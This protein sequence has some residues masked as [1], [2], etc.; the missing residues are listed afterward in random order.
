[1]FGGRE[2]DNKCKVFMEAVPDRTAN[3]LL[4]II[5]KWV[6]PGP[7][8]WSDSW[9]SYNRI[10]DLPEGYKHATVNHSQ[11]FVD[12]ESGTCTNRIESDWRHGKAEFPRFGTRPETYSSYLAV[13]MW[14]RKY[15]GEYL[16]MQ[17][18]RDIARIHPGPVT[19]AV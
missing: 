19:E 11:N 17:L 10:P 16:F 12:P 7:I 5:Q 3:T 14:K 2:K 6:A 8:I 13:F 4:T 9:K 18:I 15:A 1:M